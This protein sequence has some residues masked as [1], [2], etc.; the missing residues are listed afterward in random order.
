MFGVLM[1]EKREKREGEGVYDSESVLYF[2][3]L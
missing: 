3:T 1:R 2:G